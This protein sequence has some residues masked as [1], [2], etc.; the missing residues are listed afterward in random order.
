MPKLSEAG[1]TRKISISQIVETGNVRTDYSDIENI[2]A[3]IK[4]NTLLEP[5]LVKIL[6]PG[7]DGDPRYELIAGHRRVRAH[8]YLTEKGDDFSSIEAKIVT[9]DK[10]TLQLIENLQRAD[11]DPRDREKAIWQMSQEDG[12]TQRDI[13]AELSKTETYVSR[14]ITAYKNRLIAENAG[15]DTSAL[16]TLVLAEIHA[17]EKD[18]PML[19]NYTINGGGTVAAARAIMRDYRPPKKRDTAPSVPEIHIEEIDRDSI[20]PEGPVGADIGSLAGN[21]EAPPP[22]TA[23]ETPKGGDGMVTIHK[24]TAQ[25][26][27]TQFAGRPPLERREIDHKVV[28]LNDVF[29]EVYGYRT[30]LEQRIRENPNAEQAKIDGYKKEAALDIIALVQKRFDD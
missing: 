3:S 29:S 5:I 6:E 8:R 2:A 19:V 15:I 26:P 22:V 20:P 21:A 11:L 28:D 9:G 4:K 24:T 14:Q 12:I 16:E 13:A 27:T 1:T 17:E 30:A 10:L 7:A 25:G 23:T 18:V